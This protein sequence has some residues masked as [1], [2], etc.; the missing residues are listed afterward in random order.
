M[1]RL[2]ALSAAALAAAATL[3][4]PAI[5]PGAEAQSDEWGLNV[6]DA[7]TYDYP[8][9]P[10]AQVVCIDGT[11]PENIEA[12]S[13]IEVSDRTARTV[14][15]DVYQNTAATCADTPDRT[16]TINMELGEFTALVIG[17]DSFITFAYDVS[18]TPP[19]DTRVLVANGGDDAGVST[20]D[21][22]ARSETSGDVVALAKS[23]EVGT[24]GSY[25]DLPADN[26]LIE[27][28]TP[29]ADPNGGP[30]LAMVGAYDFD[31]AVVYDLYLAGG[32]DGDVGSFTDQLVTIACATE[33]PPPTETT[34]ST[35]TTTP[36]VAPGDAVPAT[37]V[38]GAA[39]YTG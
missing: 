10:F 35:T 19:G 31:E 26:Y 4:A 20:V 28:F 39:A 32:A 34:P 2:A 17:W 22:Y 30:P 6:I 37:P 25:V 11:G 29:G 33:E 5:V 14:T 18:C 13:I 24:A 8:G 23:L 21:V 15:V 27:L 12:G 38:S 9:A 3:V 16:T 1:K 7:A 36:V